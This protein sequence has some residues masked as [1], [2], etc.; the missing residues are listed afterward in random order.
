MFFRKL[1]IDSTLFLQVEKQE[2]GIT[3]PSMSSRLL[4][5]RADEMKMVKAY[6]GLGK[7]PWSR[8]RVP[9]FGLGFTSN[10]QKVT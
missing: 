7:K 4:D 10:L 8:R 2:V 6:F 5:P 3:K 1:F 9:G